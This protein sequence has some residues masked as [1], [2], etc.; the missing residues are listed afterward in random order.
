M[1]STEILYLS[2]ME[3]NYLIQF[4]GTVLVAVDGYIVLD[5][6]I[7][8]PRGGGQLVDTGLLEWDDGTIHA[9]IVDV[10]RKNGAIRHIVN[11]ESPLPEEGAPVKGSI[12]WDRR[13]GH[14]RMHT[15]QHIFI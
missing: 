15:A 12:D 13:Y 5:R 11:D 2:D 1:V 14:M 10:V 8:Y 3:G 9:E 4:D 7:F 6:T